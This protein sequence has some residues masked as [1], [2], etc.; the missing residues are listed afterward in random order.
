MKNISIVIPAHRASHTL[1]SAITSILDEQNVGEVIIGVNSHDATFEKALELMAKYPDLSFKILPPESEVLSASENFSRV[2]AEATLPFT[3]LLC[4]D[5]RVIAGS[6]KKQLD[7]LISIPSAPFV[8]GKRRIESTSGE[9]LFASRGGSFLPKS[10]SQ[11][12]FL[13][14]LCLTGSNPIGEPS[15]VLFRTKWLKQALPWN[16]ILPF[17]IDLDFYLRTMKFAN[18]SALF[19][20]ENVSVFVISRTAWSFSIGNSQSFDVFQFI[21]EHSKLLP[22]PEWLYIRIGWVMSSISMLGRKIMY[23]RI[24]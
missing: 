17:A 5:D 6:L 10:F 2:C 11:R 8:G 22:Y 13:I 7:L 23:I 24:R 15:A 12:D 3:K 1:D 21:K 9:T 4:A 18:D 19:L 14:S 16:G 20:A